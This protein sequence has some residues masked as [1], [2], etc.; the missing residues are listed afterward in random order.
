MSRIGGEGC[1]P[2]PGQ[3]P[4]E[5]GPPGASSPPFTFSLSIDG[6]RAESRQPFLTHH[7]TGFSHLRLAQPQVEA[8]H[9]TW[10]LCGKAETGGASP[11]AAEVLVCV[12]LTDCRTLEAAEDPRL[13]VPVGCGVSKRVLV[14]TSRSPP[15]QGAGSSTSWT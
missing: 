13:V 8:D 15:R 10:R 14:S 4:E 9:V 3:D 12:V 11:V 5:G 1:I 6:G 7:L 2:V